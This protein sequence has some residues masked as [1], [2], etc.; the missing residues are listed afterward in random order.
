MVKPQ[1]IF[2]KLGKIF[3]KL[4][5]S[6]RSQEY[7]YMNQKEYLSKENVESIWELSLLQ[8]E[9]FSQY[10][11]DERKGNHIIRLVFPIDNALNPS[12]IQAAWQQVVQKTPLLR[13]VLRKARNRTVQ[14]VLKEYPAHIEIIDAAVFPWRDYP[15]QFNLM[16]E[17][18]VRLI[19]VRQTDDRKFLFLCCHPVIMDKHSLISL[20]RDF[21]NVLSRS[22]ST[23][24]DGSSLIRPSFKE[25]LDWLAQQYWA[26][27]LTY[28]QKEFTDF[29]SATSLLSYIRFDKK[30]TH[31]YLS[32]KH[33]LTAEQSASLACFCREEGWSPTVIVQA[34]WALLLNIYSREK[35][36]YFG[37][38]FQGPPPYVEIKE[39]QS[40]IGPF[41][42]ILPIYIIIDNT[43]TAREFLKSI[44]EKNK[45]LRQYSYLPLKE[46]LP[47]SG[48]PLDSTL[49]E[50]SICVNPGSTKFRDLGDVDCWQDR[51]HPFGLEISTGENEKWQ[52]TFLCFES[53]NKLPEAV[54]LQV[55]K[56]L[57][58]IMK[59]IREKPGGLLSQLNFLPTEESEKL[60]EFNRADLHFPVEWLDVFMHQ[61]FAEQVAKNPMIVACTWG[62]R[63]VSYAEL[64]CRA[65]RLA[66]WLKEQGFGTGDLVAIFCER[67]IEMLIGILATFKAGCAYIPLDPANP[68][69][70]IKAILLDSRA[71]VVF[72]GSPELRRTLRLVEE[73]QISVCIFCLDTFPVT[74]GETVPAP[75]VT[76]LGQYASENPPLVNH[77]RDI[78]YIIFTSGSTGAP[79]GAI[80]EHIGMVN[81]LWTKIQLLQLSP[82]SRVAQNASHCFDISVWQFLSALM[83]GGQTVI[84]S[85][86]VAMTPWIFKKSLWNSRVNMLEMVPAMIETILED[87]PGIEN[88][89]ESRVP[90]LHAI[91]STGEALSTALSQKWTKKYPH[92][93][94]INAY[95]PTE[96]SDDTHHR[97]VT[98]ANPPEDYYNDVPLGNIIPNFRSYILD[99]EMRILPPGCPGEICLVGIGVGK[100]YLNNPERTAGTFVKNIFNDD[101]GKVMYR[102]GDLGYIDNRGQLVFLGRIDH[103]VKVRGFRIELGEI[104]ARLRK[105]PAVKQ[106]VVIIRKDSTQQNTIIAYTVLKERILPMQLRTYL[107]ESLPHYMIPDHLVELDNLPLN[108]NGKIDRKALPDPGQLIQSINSSEIEL[109]VNQIEKKLVHIWEEVL[110]MSP[111]GVNQ[112]FFELGGHSLRVIQV[113]SRINQELGLDIPIVELFRIQTVRGLAQWIEEHYSAASVDKKPIIVKVPPAPY[114]PMSHSQQRLFFL[115]QIEP[116]N[117]AYNLTTAI[118]MHVPMQVDILKKA[119]QTIAQRQASLRTTFGWMDDKPVQFV[120]EDYDPDIW[121]KFEDL[122][123]FDAD[124]RK[125]QLSDRLQKEARFNFDLTK[126]PLFYV[127]VYKLEE[128]HYSL[129]FNMHHIIGDLWSW[130]ILFKELF[131]IYQDYIEGKEVSLPV[132]AVQYTDYAVWQD[133]CIKGS[134]FKAHEEYWDQQFA[135]E[136]PVLD[137]PM[138][139]PRPPVQKYSAGVVSGKFPG[140]FTEPL[141]WLFKEKNITSFIGFLSLFYA[142]LSRISGEEDI[143]IGIP[144]VGRAQVEIENLIGFF[145]NTLPFRLNLRGGLTFLE[146]IDRV[147]Q[148]SLE[149]YEHAEYPL[150]LIINRLNLERDL[151]RY[152]LFSVMFQVMDNETQMTDKKTEANDNKTVGG[153]DASITI[154]DV[155]TGATN[156]D[157][158]VIITENKNQGELSC[159]FIYCKDLF[160]EETIQHWVEHFIIFCQSAIRSPE[161]TASSLIPEPFEP[162]RQTIIKKHHKIMETVTSPEADIKTPKNPIEKILLNEWTSVLER[163]NIS[164]NDN[165]FRLGGHSL[166]GIKL[167]SKLRAKGINMSIN[168]LFLHQTIKTQAQY[169]L[170]THKKDDFLFKTHQEAENSF[171]NEF[172]I[173]G[174]FVVY[175]I[176]SKHYNVFYM[177]DWSVKDPGQ[178]F[179]ATARFFK[180]HLVETLCPHY[181]RPLSQVPGENQAEFF[182]DQWEF[183]SLLQFQDG[184]AADICQSVHD[185]IKQGLANFNENIIKNE[186]LK[187]YD[188][189]PIQAAHLGIANRLRIVPVTFNEYLDIQILEGT[190]LEL[191]ANH[192]L[193]RSSLGKRE[194][195]ER[196]WNEFLPPRQITITYADLINCSPEVQ[197]KIMNETYSWLAG[198][199]FGEN[200]LL[201]YVVLFRKNLQ[202]YQLTIYLDH[203]IYDGMSGDIIERQLRHIYR[204]REQDIPVDSSP[205]TPSTPAPR[206][207]SD[208][209]ELLSGGP[210]NINEAELIDFFALREFDQCKK[211][212]ETIFSESDSGRINLFYYE[213]GFAENFKEEKV[214]ELAFVVFNILLKRYFGL[215]AIPIKIVTYGRRYGELDFFD[216]VGEFIDFVPALV[217]VD[218]ENLAAMVENARRNLDKAV[219]HHINFMSF[220]YNRRLKEIWQEVG[221]LISPERLDA[222]DSMVLF[223]FSGKS[224]EEDMK[225]WK[226]QYRG[227]VG[228]ESKISSLQAEIYYTDR[229]LYFYISSTLHITFPDGFNLSDDELKNILSKIK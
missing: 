21:M 31:Q 74:Q 105:H 194:D 44:V 107:E 101:V 161:L 98:H 222:N 122:S 221:R 192:G 76:I 100:G 154:H 150:D 199:S 19:F 83:V 165:F 92:I 79:K 51:S 73:V 170:E 124:T 108:R 142:F 182:L 99:E 217:H 146:V 119:L 158:E 47:N 203:A 58:T 156:Y 109:P 16:E 17:A 223:N 173:K 18:G 183:N 29:I 190:F 35:N 160:K 197:E 4:Q 115:H 127:I 163:E 212:I 41:A 153:S 228:K 48:L 52:L 56:H 53:E 143:I 202:D 118:E 114:Y 209:V 131:I 164:L 214:W 62:N 81:H 112:N 136:I 191:I 218:E 71:K 104:E 23:D 226:K 45:Y 1:K 216:T 148:V 26:P 38:E 11:V 157:L 204:L 227:S 37:I 167:I 132:L 162:S 94:L 123:H 220:L 139:F 147:K 90:D 215:T 125:H 133:A 186:T 225:Q 55:L 67:S 106:C 168:E 189:S 198:S 97:I 134:F 82:A 59:E 117:I 20:S 141:Y 72:T 193:L 32:V 166:I 7:N 211:K 159:T 137:L 96:C 188:I 60:N 113:R 89:F 181:I 42:N 69:P 121:F 49:F 33:D 206:P 2:R 187:Q 201:Y 12:K 64:N 63:Q 224:S 213:L 179:Q 3:Q 144:E 5:N 103:Q 39:F 145:V 200:S 140:S 195:G 175:H 184:E 205:L 128:R 8:Q 78:A 151:S 88:S 68:N 155:P 80:V 120:V 40:I 54:A 24:K 116:D 13:T 85:S 27:A 9:L 110:E 36:I 65:N 129:F 77:P 177:G 22:D 87:I 6:S 174:K 93:P 208:Y 149:A 210:Q 180:N 86:D 66:H 84:F 15:V 169:I 43:K 207:Y 25:Y 152:P 126:A 10:E 135:G 70:R 91:L 50:S 219:V 229:A 30:E 185:H 14:V 111:V 178:D 196:T 57:E 130:E 46:I 172:N 171:A 176:D 34:A 138:D 95:G 61:I 102:T 28:W 75:D